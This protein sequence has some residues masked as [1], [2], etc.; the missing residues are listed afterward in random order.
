MTVSVGVAATAGGWQI[1]VVDQ[2]RPLEIHTLTQADEMLDKVSSISALYPEPTIVLASG[3][4]GPFSEIRTLVEAMTSPLAPVSAEPS[5]LANVLR[6]LSTLSLQSYCAP[7]VAYLS[8]LP[9]YRKLLRADTGSASEVCAAMTL[10]HHMRGQGAAWSEMNFLS[11]N[12][13]QAGTSILVLQNG[14]IVNGVGRVAGSGRDTAEHEWSTQEQEQV[15][16]WEGLRQELAGLMAIHHIEDLVIRGPASE[17]VTESLAEVYQV[18]HFPQ[19][20]EIYKGYEAALGAALIA[21]GL[22]QESD[23]GEL[24]EHLLLLHA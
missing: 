10:L 20:Q 23:A 19:P 14:Q 21:E 5:S 16:F 15:A 4:P 18:Y 11:V 13:D 2:G 9:P 7:S 8:S 17:Q 24:L 6:R 12:V 3:Q 22:N 1:C